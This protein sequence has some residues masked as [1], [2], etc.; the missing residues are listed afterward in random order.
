MD[1]LLLSV[2]RLSEKFSVFAEAELAL[3][4]IRERK[5]INNVTLSSYDE[6]KWRPGFVAGLGMTLTLD[7]RWSLRDGYRQTWHNVTT[8]TPIAPMAPK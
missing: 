3:G 8:S 7:E 5:S 4:I 2:F 1:I 6:N